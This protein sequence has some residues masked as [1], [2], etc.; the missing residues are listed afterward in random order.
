MFCYTTQRA[1]VALLIM[2][3]EAVQRATQ[4]KGQ[5][6]QL[7]DF[8]NVKPHPS[9]SSLSRATFPGHESQSG[10]HLPPLSTKLNL[11]PK[12]LSTTRPPKYHHKSGRE[13]TRIIE[14]MMMMMFSLSSPAYPVGIRY[15]A[16]NTNHTLPS[17]APCCCRL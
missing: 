12:Q 5:S 11:S 13:H 14:Q 15:A 6:Q 8:V 9:L 1:N 17:T 4:L 2:S 3:C 10:I 16:T 7:T